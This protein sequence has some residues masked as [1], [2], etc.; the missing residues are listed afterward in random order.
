MPEGTVFSS[1]LAAGNEPVPGYVLE[2]EL[3]SG[4]MGKV[5]VATTGDAFESKKAIKFIDLRNR[6]GGKEWKALR[7]VKERG[8][9]HPN[10]LKLINYWLKDSDGRVIPRSEE[11]LDQ[12]Q[13]KAAGLSESRVYT[14]SATIP[15]SLSATEA[16]ADPEWGTRSGIDARAGKQQP[17]PPAVTKNAATLV[18]RGTV[19]DLGALDA[20]QANQSARSSTVAT[21]IG[22][23]RQAVELIVAMELGD[24][25]LEARLKEHQLDGREGIPQDELLEYMEQ[26]A[27][28]LDYLD[29]QE[30]IHRDVKPANILI[31]NGVTKVSD[32]GLV[33]D[34]T[35]DL[36]KTSV[37]CSPVYAAP[38]AMDNDPVQGKS[39]QYSLAVTYIELLTGRLPYR[40]KDRRDG[41]QTLDQ[42]DVYS[43]K[44]T[45][46][47]EL[48]RIGNRR[49]RQVLKKALANNPADRFNSCSEF[50][51][52]LER[53]DQSGSILM[54]L[55][56]IAA[57]LL[58]L[59]GGAGGLSLLL[60]PGAPSTGGTLAAIQAD[61]ETLTGELK[62]LAADD[63]RSLEKARQLESSATA[64]GERL[65]AFETLHPNEDVALPKVR[66]RLLQARL[67][68]GKDEWNL[69]KLD[70]LPRAESLAA[71]QR[72]MFDYLRLMALYHRY[73]NDGLKQEEHWSAVEASDSALGPQ[74]PQLEASLGSWER[75]F[76]PPK[77]ASDFEKALVKARDL[78][79]DGE[80]QRART[81]LE[82]IQE[83]YREAR[84]DGASESLRYRLEKLHLELAMGSGDRP[85]LVRE[86]GDLWDRS[87]L[88]NQD[89]DELAALRLLAA[90]ENGNQAKALDEPQIDAV[91]A[92][93]D[94]TGLG[95]GRLGKGEI[96]AL[97]RLRDRLAGQLASRTTLPQLERIW[98]Y[99]EDRD[100]L[101]QPLADRV[102]LKSDADEAALS[103]AKTEYSE[104]YEKLKLGQ[105]RKQEHAPAALFARI[106]LR[107]KAQGDTAELA[108]LQK[109]V[110]DDHELS[111]VGRCRELL[112][113]MNRLGDL[114]SAD[115]AVALLK[116][117]L[118]MIAAGETSSLLSTD[119]RKLSQEI[120]KLK[121]EPAVQKDKELANY[122]AFLQAQLSSEP[123]PEDLWPEASAASST[124]AW[125]TERRKA[126]AFRSLVAQADRTTPI[127]AKTDVMNLAALG[128]DSAQTALRS[129]DRASLLQPSDAH[130]SAAKTI[131][132][133]ILAQLDELDGR[134]VDWTSLF[135]TADA[136]LRDWDSTPNQSPWRLESVQYV[137]ALSAIRLSP[138][139]ARPDATWK[140]IGIFADLLRDPA[141]FD[142]QLGEQ[143]HD[144]AIVE[145]ILAKTLGQT[146]VGQTLSSPPTAADGQNLA[147]LYAVKGRILERDP[148]LVDVTDPMK[149]GDPADSYSRAILAASRAF[150]NALRLHNAVQ[151]AAGYGRLLI[152]LPTNLVNQDVH[153]LRLRQLID[154]FDAKGDSGNQ[155]L[156][157]IGGWVN[158]V[159][160]TKSPT[161]ERLLRLYEA[162]RRYGTLEEATRMG[163]ADPYGIRSLGLINAGNS[164]VHAAFSKEVRSP[165]D[166]NQAN[167]AGKALP[168]MTKAEHLLEARRLADLAKG[169]E[170]RRLPENA[171]LVEGNACED[172]AWYCKRTE[173]Y[174][175]S[176]KAFDTAVQLAGEFRSSSYALTYRGRCEFRCA[177]DI[178]ALGPRAS[179]QE[180]R[181]H[182]DKYLRKAH[183]TLKQATEA[184]AAENALI[185]PEA[186]LWLAIV[187]EES[188]KQGPGGFDANPSGNDGK[189]FA[190]LKAAL[191]DS[192]PDKAAESAAAGVEMAERLAV[193]KDAH[194]R[195]LRAV[196][197]ARSTRHD[198]ATIQLGSAE[199]TLRLADELTKEIVDKKV[200]PSGIER[201]ALLE[202]AH[203]QAKDVFDSAAA[204]KAGLQP[205]QAA[206][207]LTI[208]VRVGDRRGGPPAALAALREWR[209][210]AVF[211]QPLDDWRL[212]LIQVLLLGRQLGDEKAIQDAGDVLAKIDDRGLQ[213]LGTGYLNVAKGD[214]ARASGKP[215]EALAFY[216]DAA[217]QL[218]RGDDLTAKNA[219]L[220]FAKGTKVNA[221]FLNDY[222]GK[223][224]KIEAHLLRSAL[225]SNYGPKS[226]IFELLRDQRPKVNAALGVAGRPFPADVQPIAQALYE[227]SKVNFFLYRMPR[228]NVNAEDFSW[229]ERVESRL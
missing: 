127:H 78:R 150:E 143:P 54:P 73:R 140:A 113:S 69:Q 83:D 90:T 17:P 185:L 118:E 194:E 169:E 211:Q 100:L 70:A 7:V 18:G 166:V 87:G 59:I 19:P 204:M 131:A 60:R 14:L 99:V 108:K 221:I 4:A 186:E 188:V 107:R 161:A 16:N 20:T 162:L 68:V 145:S 138:E 168:D 50:V 33:V 218:F 128:R 146:V 159:E 228:A 32:Y 191:L 207:A 6:G 27:R 137:Y 201:E 119:Q 203:S 183:A 79:L 57:A 171:F 196:G 88:V 2:R 148:S 177:T 40:Y 82:T 67:A 179:V 37:A 53:A 51:K 120:D 115:A 139:T 85:Q 46:N 192:R 74:R 160:S 34:S 157:L 1:D 182:R 9:V 170:R 229:L 15:R 200:A 226:K 224:T 225:T 222:E 117:E 147:Y 154:E 41:T 172:L 223:L 189:T 104:L 190:E 66:L 25:T 209:T 21:S 184:A 141:L 102:L 103:R 38:E 63:A 136:A 11:P 167:P 111:D 30:I 135:Q 181:T 178:Y 116:I 156:L 49:A 214:A 13:V 151:Y 187:L 75:R 48:S 213:K 12:A 52:A 208:L 43:A 152:K 173:H 110:A 121:R 215:E 8:L 210:K 123:K 96:A 93:V 23:V 125:R 112:A 197:H 126:I 45:G 26:S 144:R 155:S 106:D 176:I 206:T 122:A 158:Y 89:R 44:T 98:P 133:G 29:K 92:D 58:L 28:G 76:Y 216:R 72:A 180:R 129:L 124:V 56:G 198:W 42:P 193:W 217:D 134:T 84:S 80:L 163:A 36:S 5:W 164:H 35:A 175:D 81:R 86:A 142:E 101:C 55:V 22:T 199:L 62:S 195:F 212:Q 97:T 220:L 95:A 132:Q 165:D 227:F 105:F 91:F 61:I 205:A 130:V 202:Q 219:Q 31:V 94:W 65:S 77:Q 64:L 24:K 114:L 71:D 174:D 149:D 39:D 153:V 47:Y 10:L 3:G 109:Y